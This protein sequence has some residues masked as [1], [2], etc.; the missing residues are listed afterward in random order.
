MASARKA[1]GCGKYLIRVRV[2][3]WVRGRVSPDPNP[4]LDSGVCRLREVLSVPTEARPARPVV[5]GVLVR[6]G[7]RVRV[8]VRVRVRGAGWG[9]GWG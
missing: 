6:V 3:V 4:T 9:W 8:R 7:A 2:R 1:S 5:R